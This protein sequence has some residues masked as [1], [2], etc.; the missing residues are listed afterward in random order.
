M[1][2]W[3][4]W[5]FAIRFGFFD[6]ATYIEPHSQLRALASR[7][8]FV[9]NNVEFMTKRLR[10]AHCSDIHLD[11]D[12]GE[13]IEGHVDHYKSGFARALMEMQRHKPDMLLI[14]GDLFDANTA[15][16][17]TITWAMDILSDQPLPIV[18]IPGNH[19][20]LE[21]GAIYHRYD[22]NKI[23]NLQ[24]ID[25]EEGATARVDTLDVAVWG[26][27][28]VEHSPDFLPLDSCPERP[29]DCSWYL[30]MGH[31]IFVPHGGETDRSSPIPM[32]H[33]EDSVCDYLA[34]GHHHAAMELVNEK[35]TAA[36]SG[37]PTD[38]I[39]RGATYV[40]IDLAD[41]AAPAVNVHE[42]S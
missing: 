14:A 2:D 5:K 39:G 17:E 15:S 31:G 40:I 13:M 26:K 18:M 11:G 28:M 24:M 38:T 7:H 37:S 36:Y 10:F 3:G 23:P 25:A 16:D 9:H 6:V 8:F 22:F 35:A 33:I 20:C 12:A 19:D 4:T 34:L 32:Q 1:G 27:G 21:P 42:I 29:T 41:D 30:G